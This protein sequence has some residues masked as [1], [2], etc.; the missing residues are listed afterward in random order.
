MEKRI[1]KISPF[2]EL[3]QVTYC[4]NKLNENFFDSL[5]NLSN[6]LKKLSLMNRKVKSTLM[7]LFVLTFSCEK[8]NELTC[9]TMKLKFILNS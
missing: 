2:L 4:R 7:I 3:E 8:V 5:Y 9:F 6:Y 1:L